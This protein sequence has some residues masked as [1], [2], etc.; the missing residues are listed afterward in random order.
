[1]VAASA[2]AATLPNSAFCAWQTTWARAG[3]GT[4]RGEGDGHNPGGSVISRTV[5]CTLR[6]DPGCGSRAVLACMA[7]PAGGAPVGAHGLGRSPVR[8]AHRDGVHCWDGV[9][10]RGGA[11][12]YSRSN[13]RRSDAWR[14][15]TR[16]A[17]QRTP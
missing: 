10:G 7:S 17:Q 9:S 16:T 12:K 8:S 2:A 5:R 15:T 3:L 4:R 6:A 11:Q 13:R 1:V 14:P